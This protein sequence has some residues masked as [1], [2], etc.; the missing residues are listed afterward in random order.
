MLHD[1]LQSY[2]SRRSDMEDGQVIN[3]ANKDEYGDFVDISLDAKNKE[4]S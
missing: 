1:A 3:Q 4:T 2:N